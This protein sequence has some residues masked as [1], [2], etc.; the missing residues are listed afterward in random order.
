MVIQLEYDSL[1]KLDWRK[2]NRLCNCSNCNNTYF[3]QSAKYNDL[4]LYLEDCLSC[5]HG[6][7]YCANKDIELE[8]IY[9][10]FFKG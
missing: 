1:Y 9:N 2:T 10:P 5:G 4:I 8:C 6:E 7:V 3:K